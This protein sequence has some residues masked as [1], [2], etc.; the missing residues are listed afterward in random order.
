MLFRSP[1]TT[2]NS[3]W[4]STTSFEIGNMWPGNYFWRVKARSSNLLESNWSE[5]WSFSVITTIVSTTPTQVP[6]FTP[7]PIS[8]ITPTATKIPQPGFIELVDNLS[9]HTE[10]GNWPPKNGQKLIAHIK[11]RNGG[12][13]PIHIEHLGVRGRRNGDE[14]WDIGFWTVDLNGHNEW[15]LTPN[16]ERPL[17]S[18]NYSFRISY[19]LNGSTW[20]EIGNEINFTVP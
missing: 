18:G 8:S 1:Y 20:V 14:S 12:D 19:T 4:I 5:T 17:Q 2:L 16:N 11:I 6:T 15:E 9:L 13:L 10:S 3:G 7:T